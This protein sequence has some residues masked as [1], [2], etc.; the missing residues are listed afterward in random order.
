MCESHILWDPPDILLFHMMRVLESDTFV[1][2]T[3]YLD[4]GDT[5]LGNALHIAPH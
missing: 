4:K 1:G 3:L 5:L 2:N